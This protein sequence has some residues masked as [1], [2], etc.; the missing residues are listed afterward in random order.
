MNGY[1][2][3]ADSLRHA[4][5]TGQLTEEEAAPRLKALDFLAGCS[6]EEINALFDATAF[7]DIAKGYLYFA[8]DD[9]KDMSDEDK[10]QIKN[11]YAY[12][13]DTKSAKEA[14][15]RYE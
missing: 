11:N 10:Q 9:I 15:K 8:L 2:M 5:E 14:R 12:M 7:N 4:V 3:Y 13:L 6:R 1:K